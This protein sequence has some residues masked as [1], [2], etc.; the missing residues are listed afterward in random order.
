M[1]AAAA[2]G[3]AAAAAAEAATAAEDEAAA[4]AAAAPANLA[5]EEATGEVDVEPVAVVAGGVPGSTSCEG[6]RDPRARSDSTSG[7]GV[8]K[9]GGGSRGRRAG[10][11]GS[12]GGRRA[13]L[14]E[15]GTGAGAEGA[16]A[17]GTWKKGNTVST[18]YMCLEVYT[19]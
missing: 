4:A 19:R 6:D 3:I 12:G 13:S 8:G 17:V 16:D 11:G 15:G 9:P 2:E 10:G 5:V 7:E 1:G 14:H 18:K